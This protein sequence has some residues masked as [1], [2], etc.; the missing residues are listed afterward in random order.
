M[1]REAT[2][3]EIGRLRG[4]KREHFLVEFLD[5]VSVKVVVY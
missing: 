3:E 4:G 5:K 1:W 2:N